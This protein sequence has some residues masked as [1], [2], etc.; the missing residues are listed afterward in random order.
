MTGRHAI[1]S[2]NWIG[3][4]FAVAVDQLVLAEIVINTVGRNGTD[5]VVDRRIAT[6]MVLVAQ[7]AWDS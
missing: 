1:F 7:V 3:M 4:I 5:N 2:W 6:M